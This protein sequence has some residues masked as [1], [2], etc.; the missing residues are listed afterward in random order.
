MV[1]RDRN[2]YRRLRKERRAVARFDPT[3]HQRESGLR[4]LAKIR[5]TLAKAQPPDDEGCS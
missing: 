4:W 5:E 1:K 3:E 2:S